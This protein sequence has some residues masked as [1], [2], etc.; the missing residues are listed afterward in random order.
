MLLS[1]AE[2]EPKMSKEK[3]TE[4]FARP[5]CRESAQPVGDNQFCGGPRLTG[6][7][8]PQ[9]VLASGFLSSFSSSTGF[10]LSICL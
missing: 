6:H 7:H 4:Y 3:K 8:R 1:A 2:T 5:H 10:Q 9:A